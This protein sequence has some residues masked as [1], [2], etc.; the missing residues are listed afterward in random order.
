MGV[1]VA[2]RR[3][4]LV[5]GAARGVGAETARALASRGHHVLVNYRVKR[6]RAE[7]LVAEIQERGGVATAIGA[8]ITQPRSLSALVARV[9]ELTGGLDALVLNA[10]GGLERGADAGYPM[11]INRD[12]QVTLVEAMTPLLRPGSRVVFVT[13]HQA[14]FVGTHEVPADY[15]PVAASKSAGEKAIRER[16]AGLARKGIGVSVVSGD[17]IEGTMIVR[18]LERRDPDAVG[19][20]RDVAPLPTVNE[21]ASAVADEATRAGTTAISVFVGGSD[22]L[23]S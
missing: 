6:T 9:S 10:S 8:D 14:H 23:A 19:T 3:V 18:L 7:S 11:R 17:M 22:Y 20:R 13:S 16:Q 4:I 2:D 21:F 1:R 5:T 12:A 15:G